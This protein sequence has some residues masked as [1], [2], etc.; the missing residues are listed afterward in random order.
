MNERI[1]RYK[2]KIFSAP[3]EICIERPKYYTESYKKTEGEHPAIRAAKAFK[4]LIE[5]MTIYILPEEIIVGNRTS[6]ILAPVIPIERGEINVV[7]KVDLKNLLKRKTQPFHIEKKDKKELMKKI[8][9][10]WKGKTVKE[11]RMKLLKK[12]KLVITPGIGIKSW[13]KRGRQLGGFSWLKK[14]YDILVKGRLR[15]ITKG[16]SLLATNNPNF[17]NNVFD[18]Q[19]HFVHGHANLLK[20]GGFSKVKEKALEQLK[21]IEEKISKNEFD[22]ELSSKLKSRVS[23]INVKKGHSKNPE[24]YRDLNKPAPKVV[25]YISPE[26][27]SLMDKKAFLEAVCICCDAAKIYAD[28]FVDLALKMAENE[29]DEIRKEE[30]KKIAEICSQVPWK[31]PRNF[32]EAIQMVWFNQVLSYLSYGIG[33]IIAI[34][35]PDQYLYPYYLIDKKKGYDDKY[36]LTLIE[37]LLIKTSINLLPLPSYAKFTASELGGDNVGIC[38]GGVDENG[39]DATNEL[40]YLFM[41]AIKEL[42]CMTNSF[43]IRVSSKSSDKWFDKIVDVCSTTSGPAIFNDDIIIKALQKTGLSLE[44]ARNY[45]IIGCVEPSGA[46]NTH[47]CTSGNDI[48]LYGI[49]EQVLTNGRIRSWSKDSGLKIGDPCSF[50]TYEEFYQAYLKQLKYWIDF[51]VKWV[52]IKDII[53]AN[54]YP[55][56]FISSTIEG[57]LENKADMTQG[58][59]KYNMSSISGRGFATTVD[60]L[61]V[62]KKAVYEKGLITMR[63]LTKMLSRNYKGIKAEK[64][65]QELLNKFP[66]YGNDID[67]VDEIAV[68]LAS[69][70]CDLVSINKCI[71]T[72]KNGG[73]YRPGFFSYGMNVSDG[74]F[75]GASPDGRLAGQAVSNSMSPSN[76]AEKNGLTSMLN[77]VSKIDYTKVS[78]GYSVNVRLPMG[79]FNKKE[80]KK[81]LAQ[82]IKSYFKMGG[83][84]IQF[85]II[86]HEVLLDAQKRPELYKDLVV[87]VTGYAVYF[88]DLG[89]YIQDD[90]IARYQF[91]CL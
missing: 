12:G 7:M 65:R 70:F 10:Y 26:R 3:Y 25:E 67:D 22:S 87:R 28:R 20:I 41:D 39:N 69:D 11:M 88:I 77:S 40:S 35:R 82:I 45:G 56:P 83:S 80:N 84:H 34:G 55:N 54:F 73:I 81:K 63:E 36:F 58:G 52:D 19:G 90:I 86:D 48:N 78:N 76:N 43:S 47:S 66:K 50:K 27:L 85:N 89:K 23:E 24:D 49:L 6:K 75:L 51:I 14:F 21:E 37:D 15:Y 8:L 57:C 31:N 71:H 32:H 74:F 53:Y 17:V 61:Y 1:T 68:R 60:S 38:V 4:H 62:I 5:N 44:D 33:A 13:I 16:L 79:I 91:Q 18:T 30:L 2:E 64:F 29:K 72:N 42:K 9:P 59:S 46:G